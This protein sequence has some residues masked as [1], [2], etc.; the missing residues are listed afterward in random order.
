MTE[1]SQGEAPC[2]WC[3]E[4]LPVF[5]FFTNGEGWAQFCDECGSILT[6]DLPDD[7]GDPAPPTA[8]I[9]QIT[10]IQKAAR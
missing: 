8:A 7:D 6:G 9:P 5:W 2:N 1:N 3:G 4:E 10:Q